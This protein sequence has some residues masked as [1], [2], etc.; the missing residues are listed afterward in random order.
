MCDKVFKEN[1][2]MLGFTHICFKDQRMCD[3]TVNNYFYALRFL[4]MC[5][6]VVGTYPSG[7]QFVLECY[8]AVIKLFFLKWNAKILSR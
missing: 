6:N 1:W 3:K 2:G 7:I 8:N 4:K 5:N